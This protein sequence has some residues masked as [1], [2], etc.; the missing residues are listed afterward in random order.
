MLSVL[1]L[2]VT[3]LLNN[4]FSFLELHT[5]TIE[6]SLENIVPHLLVLA[7]KGRVDE[8]DPKLLQR[9][10]LDVVRHIRQAL[11]YQILYA[12]LLLQSVDMYLV[13]RE[14][15][16]DVSHLLFCIFLLGVTVST[17]SHNLMKQLLFLREL[18]RQE[19]PAILLV[20]EVI[21]TSFFAN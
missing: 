7:G 21:D 13:D 11:L 19:L 10:L 8:L 12:K 5:S 18:L 1:L 14:L 9:H 2:Q 16:S 15:L 17:I 3:Y 20:K 4:N 6:L